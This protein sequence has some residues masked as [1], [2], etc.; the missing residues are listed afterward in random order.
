M[1]IKYKITTKA[2]NLMEN[3]LPGKVL[4]PRHLNCEFYKIY[5]FDFQ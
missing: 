3:E 4:V 2:R 5:P 1:T